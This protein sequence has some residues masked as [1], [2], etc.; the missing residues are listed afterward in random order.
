MHPQTPKW[1]P[2]MSYKRSST[3]A[4]QP[5][6]PKPL[7]KTL[8]TSRASPFSKTP[9]HSSTKPSQRKIKASKWQ[10]EPIKRNQACMR[11][12]K[13]KGT[14]VDPIA[15]QSTTHLE[16]R[17]ACWTSSCTRWGAI[18]TSISMMTET[19]PMGVDPRTTTLTCTLKVLLVCQQWVAQTRPPWLQPR[20][21][22]SNASTIT[23]VWPPLLCKVSKSCVLSTNAETN[24]MPSS[25]V[26]C[27]NKTSTPRQRFKS[28]VATK[29]PRTACIIALTMYPRWAP[30]IFQLR[31]SRTCRSTRQF[32]VWL[33]L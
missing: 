19:I 22:W 5:D 29:R 11:E 32:L 1:P 25:K 18:R 31:R 3:K 23:P 12:V 6:Q 28:R 7:S 24:Q 27:T 10:N 20:P 16:V 33:Q 30:R 15:T 17:A 14:K 26:S 8:A 21:P 2:Y 4:P 13:S 9:C